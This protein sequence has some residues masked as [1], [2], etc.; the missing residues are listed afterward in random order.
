MMAKL[1]IVTDSTATIPQDVLERYQITV[2]PLTVIWGTETFRDG[3]DISPTEFYTRLGK[4]SVI[5]TTTQAT[6][7][8]FKEIF[9][10]LLEED[11]DVLTILISS[12]LSGTMDSALQA[13]DMIHSSRIAIVDSRTTSMAMGF[14]VLEAARAAESGA[15]LAEAKDQAERAADNAGV[16]F[17]VDTLKYLHLGGR[18]GGGARFLGTALNLKPILELVDGHVEAIQRVISKRKATDRIFDLVG[19]RIGKRTPIHLATIHANAREEAETLL[20]RVV[21]CYHPVESYI[22]EVSPVLGVHAGPGTVGLAFMAG[23]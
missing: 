7:M 13:Q 18:I 22:T 1:A 11:Y 20:Q 12:K 6:P 3:I 5:P 4:D 21:D 9:T 23:L 8:L 15:T 2:V 16:F 10:K 19:E 17:V 14:Q